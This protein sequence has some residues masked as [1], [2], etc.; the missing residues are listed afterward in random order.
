MAKFRPYPRE[1]YRALLRAWAGRNLKLL[2][3]SAT[4]V[5]ALLVFETAVIVRVMPDIGFRWWLLGVVQAAIIAI[6]LHLMHNA[7][8]IREREAISQLRGAWGEEA[9]RDELRRAKRKRLVW[10]WIDSVEFQAGDLDHL[11]LPRK[12]G[13]VVI[14]SK[15][16]SSGTDAVEMATSARRARLRAEGLTRTLL[17]SQ[18]GSHRAKGNTV[19]VR[20]LVVIWGPAQHRVPDGCHVEGVD[21]IAGR[22]LIPWLQALPGDEVDK[23]AAKKALALLKEFRGRAS[24]AKSAVPRSRRSAN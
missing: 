3:L 19:S 13:F 21:F 11:V 8:L 14:D 2:M 18:R 23:A 1:A 10:G 24:E 20:P 12:D 4:V 16:R 6:A 5:A 17:K 15:W 22:A 7:F 9:T